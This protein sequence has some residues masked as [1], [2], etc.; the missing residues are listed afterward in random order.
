MSV[1]IVS[2]DLR[3]P[4]RNYQP[5]YDRLSGWGAIRLLESVW[6]V[7]A[8]TNATD[9]RNDLLSRMDANDGILVAI[10]Q[11]AAWNNLIGQSGPTLKRWIDG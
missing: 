4:G 9:L 3:Q 8:N 1:F 2:Y 10:T 5:L 11:G 6:A 7:N